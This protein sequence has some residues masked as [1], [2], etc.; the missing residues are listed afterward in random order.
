[1]RIGK[2]IWHVPI[3]SR[4]RYIWLFC[5]SATRGHLKPVVWSSRALK[6]GCVLFTGPSP[7]QARQRFHGVRIIELK[8]LW[9]PQTVLLLSIKMKLQWDAD[10]IE[11]IF[12]NQF[13]N[14]KSKL[15]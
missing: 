9:R 12:R 1:M 6:V 3:Y 10:I 4:L 13:T 7:A 11:T 5:F 8:Q 14:A 15:I 2:E